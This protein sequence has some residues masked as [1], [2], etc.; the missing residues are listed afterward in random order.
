MSV[1]PVELHPEAAQEAQAAVE[2]YRS[3]SLR[4]AE[5]FFRE[6][7]RAIQVVSDAPDRWP[8]FIEGT[9]RFPLRRFPYWVIYRVKRDSLQILAVAH[10]RR[11]PG[12]WLLRGT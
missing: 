8:T 12:Y 6:L 3:R 10:A 1:K 5:V 11:K 9:R 2:W 7:E 4:A